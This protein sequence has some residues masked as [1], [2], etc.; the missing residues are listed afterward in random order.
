MKS[1][2]IA[3]ACIGLLLST[4]HPVTAQTLQTQ[5]MA[6]MCK[7]NWAGA[8]SVVDRIIKTVPK[9]QK[10]QWQDYRKGL[11]SLK[12]SGNRTYRPPECPQQS[13]PTLPSHSGQ[14]TYGSGSFDFTLAGTRTTL[15]EG[16]ITPKEGYTWLIIKLTIRNRSNIAEYYFSEGSFSLKDRTGAYYEE[17]ILAQH[18]RFPVAKIGVGHTVSGEIAYEVPVG[19][20]GLILEYTPHSPAGKPLAIPLN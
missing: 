14:T 20:S 17:T 11:V 12:Q 7:G 4:A 10:P 19:I 2:H 15:G 9:D 16:S 5:L 18:Q 3:A 6:A 8:I 1:Y 13:K